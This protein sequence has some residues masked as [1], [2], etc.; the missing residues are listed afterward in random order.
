LSFDRLILPESRE[1]IVF[2]GAAESRY[3]ASTDLPE[4]PRLP[5]LAP[6]VSRF[7]AQLDQA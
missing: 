4:D 1:V 6:N 2:S 5:G 7:F 3:A